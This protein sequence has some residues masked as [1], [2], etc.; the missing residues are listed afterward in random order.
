MTTVVCNKLSIEGLS[1]DISIWNLIKAEVLLVY[2]SVLFCIV[3][4]NNNDNISQ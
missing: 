1:N 3:I 2:Y 4:I